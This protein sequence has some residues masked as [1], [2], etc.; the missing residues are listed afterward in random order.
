MSQPSLLDELATAAGIEPYY[1]DIWGA[2]HVLSVDTRRAFLAAMGLPAATD[3]ESAQSLAALTTKPWRRALD[4]VT[5]LQQERDERTVGVVVA[6]GPAGTVTWRIT[7]EDGARFEGTISCADLP[8][9]E[10]R[11]VDGRQ[12]E[13]RLLTLPGPLPLGYHR[14]EVTGDTLPRGSDAATLIVA[15]Q[16]AYLP[17]KLQHPPGIWGFSLQL[18]GLQGRES[19]G[20]GDFGDLA[21]FA[22]KAA[23]LGAGALG[24]NPLHAL[25][26]GN[27]THVSPY[28]P[29]SRRFLNPLY[30]N[31]EAVPDWEECP[32]ARAQIREPGFAAG[33]AALRNAALV[34]YPG[35]AAAKL[36]ILERL[37]AAFRVHHLQA[38][39]VRAE[40]FRTFQR[41]GGGALERYA[42]FEALAEHFRGGAPGHFSWRDWPAPYRDP[43]SPETAAFG[44]DHADRVTFQQYLQWEADRQLALAQLAGTRSGMA[45][46]VYRDL[47]LGVDAD[48][49]EAWAEQHLLAQ[50][51]SAGAPPDSFNLQGQSWGLPPFNPHALRDAGYGPFIECL[52]ANMRH[53]GA[54]R[55][56]HIPWF[57][58]LFWIPRETAASAGGYVRY[59]LDELLAITALESRRARCVVVG[60]DLGTVP[61]GLHERLSTARIL[62]TRLLYFERRDDGGFCAPQTYPDLTHVAIGTHDLPTFPGYWHDHDIA[63][64]AALNLVP[65]PGNTSM[66]RE[67]RAGARTALLAAFRDTGLLP[68]AAG[69]AGDPAIE[70]PGLVDAAYRFL[71]LSPARLLMVHLED[72]LGV[73]DQINL[74]GTVD[75]QPN[76]RRKLPLPWQTL[77]ASPRLSGFAAMLAR[78]RPP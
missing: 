55:I 11:T 41:E 51:I 70:M 17:D 72:V 71:A 34:D 29:S 40:A 1:Q 38:G 6:A 5:V 65:A 69:S 53:A 39:T 33:L 15:P 54:L 78:L 7:A 28:S 23:S 10:A 48:G 50:G 57:A 18:Y 16:Q 58:R 26:S 56:D 46:G 42:I 74:P 24:L 75:E 49:A 13:R 76:W 64:R 73:L 3:E 66:L 8:S 63:V 44:R 47:A 52:R 9:A 68:P 27:P 61:E 14:L 36:P 62:S 43:H 35:A 20:L 60:E 77:A 12:L 67:E 37:Y 21:G 59:P 4:P 22:A 31:I 45:I 25:F 19:W 32:A 2:H 30:I